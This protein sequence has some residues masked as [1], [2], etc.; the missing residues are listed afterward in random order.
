MTVKYKSKN[1]K[2]LEISLN[3]NLVLVKILY[4]SNR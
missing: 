3:C 2:L 1:Y 4:Y